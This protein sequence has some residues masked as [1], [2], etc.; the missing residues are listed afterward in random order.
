MTKVI[1][2]LALLGLAVSA[3]LTWVELFRIEAICQWCIASAVIIVALAS[4]ATV[5]ALRPSPAAQ[6]SA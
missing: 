3:Y 5:R 1:A 2:V 4:L 6:G